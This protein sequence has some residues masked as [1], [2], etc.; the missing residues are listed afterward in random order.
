MA[1]ALNLAFRI[2]MYGLTRK[3]RSTD[4]VS[5]SIPPGDKIDDVLRDFTPT[6][7]HD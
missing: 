2:N 1:I 4:T 6:L 7:L 5:L 3:Q